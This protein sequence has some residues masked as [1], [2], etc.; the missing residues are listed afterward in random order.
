MLI[1][2]I[3]WWRWAWKCAHNRR[4]IKILGRVRYAEGLLSEPSWSYHFII[5]RFGSDASSRRFFSSALCERP[6]IEGLHLV[7]VLI[8][9][10]GIPHMIIWRAQ[11]TTHNPLLASPTTSLRASRRQT[12]CILPKMKFLSRT[13]LYLSYMGWGATKPSEGS[14]GVTHVRQVS[15]FKQVQKYFTKATVWIYYKV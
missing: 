5:W 13:P 4:K 7:G 8:W 9:V 6:H 12:V 15:K 11:E 10:V 2:P 14:F 1:W 3:V